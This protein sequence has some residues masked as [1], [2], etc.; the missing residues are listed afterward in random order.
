MLIPVETIWTT[1]TPVARVTRLDDR[2]VPVRLWH[3]D[4]DDPT[5]VL[6]RCWCPFQWEG[7]AAEDGRT[8]SVWDTFAH[9][10]T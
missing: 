5:D 4:D 10:G 7:A 2:D 3:D 8:P 1:G 6:V 9:A